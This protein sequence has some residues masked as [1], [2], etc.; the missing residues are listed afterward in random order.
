MADRILGLIGLIFSAIY[1][2]GALTIQES[3]IQ[4]PLG[5]IAFPL[6]VGILFAISCLLM[7]LKPDL[8]PQWPNASKIFELM[9]VIF[10]LIAYGFILDFLGFTI[11]TFL[12]ASYLS[13][14]M[15]AP[16]KRALIAGVCISVSVY[17][18]FGK[19]LSLSLAKGVVG[20]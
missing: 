13:W 2:Y 7:I 20:F 1:I 5:P 6:I 15:G 4:D 10:I 3:F 14:R 17:F 19:I 11:S 18:V 8:P 9:L 16:P 12:I